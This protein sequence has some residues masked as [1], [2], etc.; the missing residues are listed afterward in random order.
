MEAQDPRGNTLDFHKDGTHPSG[1]TDTWAYDAEG[2]QTRAC[3]A[4]LCTQ[5]QYD[6]LGRAIQTTDP[7]GHQT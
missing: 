7:A 4:G 2:R 3:Q 1:L 5:T 6:S